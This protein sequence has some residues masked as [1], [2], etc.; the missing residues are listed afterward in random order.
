MWYHGAQYI[1]GS[2][3]CR[4]CRCHSRGAHSH[5]EGLQPEEGSAVADRAGAIRTSA[6]STFTASRMG[7]RKPDT[8]TD[9]QS[10]R[11]SSYERSDRFS[12]SFYPR[13]STVRGLR[14]LAWPQESRRDSETS[15]SCTCNSLVYTS[16][17]KVN[18]VVVTYFKVYET[19]AYSN[20]PSA[21]QN[22]RNWW[23]ERTPPETR[24]AKRKRSW[25]FPEVVKSVDD[26]REAPPSIVLPT[27]FRASSRTCSS[28]SRWRTLLI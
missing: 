4:R 8:R 23:Y 28:S 18:G 10:G 14:Y 6:Y 17:A 9:Q 12:R 25:V 21:N 19:S 27:A 24:K 22:D 16:Q 5:R 11:D 26:L 20:W 7:T 3:L 13:R 1:N 15:M 2:R